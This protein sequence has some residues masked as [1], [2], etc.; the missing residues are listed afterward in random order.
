MLPGHV[1]IVILTPRQPLLYFELKMLYMLLWTTDRTSLSCPLPR[2]SVHSRFFLFII[3][4]FYVFDVEFSRA[5][6]VTK[7]IKIPASSQ[8]QKGASKK[9]YVILVLRKSNQFEQLILIFYSRHRVPPQHQVGD[10]PPNLQL[11]NRHQAQS[12]AGNGACQNQTPLMQRCR[13]T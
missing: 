9:Q 10:L 12:R 1:C 13:R 4:S 11:Q 7:I 6:F 2:P 5:I 3:C 8:C